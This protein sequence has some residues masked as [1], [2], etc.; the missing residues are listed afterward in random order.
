[1]L[2]PSVS[3]NALEALRA[4]HQAIKTIT[5]ILS[6]KVDADV[7][8]ILDQALGEIA[9]ALEVPVAC[10]HL[11]D[12]EYG[13]LKM[14][15]GLNMDPVFSH[16]WTRLSI[17]GVSL[18]AQVF[19]TQEVHEQSASPARGGMGSVICAAI[20]GNQETIGTLSL[21]WPSPEKAPYDSD[22]LDFLETVGRLLGLALEH[23]GLVSEL[24]ENLNRLMRMQVKEEEKNRELEKLNQ[25]LRMANRRLEELSATDVLT[26][27]F[28]RRRLIER[29]EREMARSKRLGHPICLVMADLDHFKR[30]NDSLGHQAG[31]EALKLF[32]SLV[33]NGVRSIDTVARYGGEEFC[34]V[35][36]NCDMKAGVVVADKFRR[37]IAVKSHIDPFDRLGGITVSMGVAEYDGEC[38]SKELIHLAD[39]ALY[40][41]KENG[42]NRVEAAE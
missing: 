38:S 13:Q 32:A 3:I 18:Q 6:A 33:A 42:R 19:E 8:P 34:M 26:G 22:R 12:P 40:Q 4:K 37:Q 16:A 20:V 24:V 10:L 9:G 31:D 2:E 29:L 21:M 39:Q 30:V 14:I 25:D 7:L 15:S 28:N 1:L 5:G 11:A 27:V 35:L 41:A 23:A 17:G 36:V